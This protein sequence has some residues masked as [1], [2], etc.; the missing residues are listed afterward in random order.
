MEPV[1]ALVLLVP[2]LLPA[3]KILQIDL[4][5]F[6]IVVVLSLMIGLLTP[7]VGLILF[8]VAKI[9][10]VP[11]DQL[12]KSIAPFVATLLLVL[13]LVTVFPSLVL[14]LPRLLYGMPIG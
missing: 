11:I 2:I 3:I 1:P 5:H 8:I 4:V 6:G 12:I 7:P 10:D 13:L 9:A 14:F